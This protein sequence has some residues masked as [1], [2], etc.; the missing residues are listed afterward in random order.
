[1]ER[2]ELAR[3]LGGNVN[4]AVR[5]VIAEA[6]AAQ[7]RA[8]FADAVAGTGNVFLADPKWGDEEWDQFHAVLA[9]AVSLTAAPFLQNEIG[10]VAPKAQGSEGGWLMMPTGGTSGTLRL[11]RHDSATILAAV[12]GFTK[13]FGLPRVNA[14]GVLPLHHVSGLMAWMRCALTG[15]N[16]LHTD[17][18]EIEAGK[19][20]VLP[21]T[22]EGWVLSLVPTQLERLL[23]DPAAV[24]WL[25]K[26]RIIFL[27]G[28]PAWP[29]LLDY[30][31][32]ERLPLSL[33]YG[34]TETAAMVAALKPDEFLAGGR[35][36]GA[37]LPHALLKIDHDGAVTVG[38]K[39]LFRGY[40][41]GWR[42]SGVFTTED[43]GA[44]DASGRLIVLGRRDGVIITGGEKVMPAEVEA[45]LR[46]TH[47]FSDVAVLGVAHAEWGAEVV[48]AYPMGREPDL[49]KIRAAL[50]RQLARY[51]HPRQFVAV[52]SWPRNEQGK[53]NRAELARQV[54][55][56]DAGG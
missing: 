31:A 32:N 48:A 44:L 27:G 22:P 17:W 12:G 33:G 45:V 14:V 56:R 11:A 42:E 50:T 28:G 26:F 38:G 5:T 23:R 29:E 10:L 18:K 53:L 52:E 24:E 2:T 39:S 9:S 6:N 37:A 1:M 54:A 34:M 36:S 46:D 21:A 13:R 19:R 20:P 55:E 43:L 15:G 40:Y 47:E 4:H 49:E 35:N 8:K 3:L 16:Y 7:F 51:K 30:A 41:P 25:R